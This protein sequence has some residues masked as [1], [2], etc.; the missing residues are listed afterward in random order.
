M[1]INVHI[2]APDDIQF[3]QMF[4]LNLGFVVNVGVMF[5]AALNIWVHG[6]D[7]WAMALQCHQQ[8]YFMAH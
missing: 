7:A 3:I 8:N 5:P 4:N 2:Y 6:H 1:P